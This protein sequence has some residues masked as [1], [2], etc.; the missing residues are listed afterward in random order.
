MN[1]CYYELTWRCCG[2]LLA[3]N[4]GPK[5]ANNKA[6]T[7]QKAGVSEEDSRGIFTDV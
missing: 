4:H 6:V 5:Q 2:V 7:L 1:S 3:A